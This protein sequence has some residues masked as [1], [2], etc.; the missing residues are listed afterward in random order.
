[1]QAV[2]GVGALDSL[3]EPEFLARFE[4]DPP[5]QYGMVA[6]DVG[7]AVDRLE[8]AGAGPFLKATVPAPGWTE[9]GHKR[10]VRTELALGYQGDDQIEVL[11]AGEGTDIY[12]PAIPDDG[13]LGF[14]H[15]GIFQAEL[16]AISQRLGSAGY[17]NV[18]RGGLHLGIYSTQFA[19]FDTRDE[20]GCYLEVVE[21][22]LL[23]DHSPPGKGVIEGLAKLMRRF[24]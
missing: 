6:A 21:F 11:G 8:E 2:L 16:D 9:G 19:Y 13:S 17:P 18:V 12:A 1:M 7:G 10:K 4:L 15:V 5:R 23:G 3:I 22:K 20:L 24:R 14:H